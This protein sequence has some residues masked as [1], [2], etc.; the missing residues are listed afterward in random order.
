ME[1]AW[2]I[3]ERYAENS[4]Y[5][6]KLSRPSPLSTAYRGGDDTIVTRIV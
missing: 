1:T 4:G 6:G 3:A 2:D 5:Y